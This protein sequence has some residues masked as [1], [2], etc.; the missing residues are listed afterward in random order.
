MSFPLDHLDDSVAGMVA[1]TRGRR[2]AML[3]LSSAVYPHMHIFLQVGST[4]CTRGLAAL[5]AIICD[6]NRRLPGWV[7]VSKVA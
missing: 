6:M 7:V 5:S 2:E 4:Q 1:V 3:P